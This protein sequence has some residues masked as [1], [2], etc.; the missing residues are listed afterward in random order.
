RLL[1]SA[2]A[3]AGIALTTIVVRHQSAEPQAS[4]QAVASAEYGQ[5]L[6]RYTSREMGVG[7]PDAGQ[8]YSGN[9][10]D[11]SSCHLDSGQQPGMLS[12]LE[13]ASKYPTFSGRDGIVGDLA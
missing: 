2:A 7:Q 5:R 4:N 9:N 12:L 11:C 3:L 10:L 1:I 8:R 13:T 6:I